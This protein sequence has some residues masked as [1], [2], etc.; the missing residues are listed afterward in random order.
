MEEAPVEANAPSA[1]EAGSSGAVGRASVIAGGG[2]FAMGGSNAE[3]TKDSWG[4]D[5]TAGTSG[6]GAVDGHEL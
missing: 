3:D 5:D 1:E 4:M 6:V 2:W